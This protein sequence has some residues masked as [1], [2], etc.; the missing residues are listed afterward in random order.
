MIA[1]LRVGPGVELPTKSMVVL[2]GIAILV[3]TLVAAEADT[4]FT[5]YATLA[6]VLALMLQFLAVVLL[7]LSMRTNT[8][9]P[10]IR[11]FKIRFT[12]TVDTE[13]VTETLMAPAQSTVWGAVRGPRPNATT[14]MAAFVT[15]ATSRFAASIV[16]AAM[17]VPVT[18]PLAM[19]DPAIVPAAM[20]ELT[21]VA[22][23]IAALVTEL[24]AKF[25][26]VMVAEAI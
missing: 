25:V 5:L 24:A 2:V 3:P 9:I 23:A 15:D 10:I 7:V 8:G 13:N 12:P 11:L 18:V 14:V 16:F 17:L 21:M 6:G 1:R 20:S 19:L 26:L 22:A 4:P